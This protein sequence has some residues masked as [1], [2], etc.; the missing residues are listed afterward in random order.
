MKQFF[1]LAV[2][3]MALAFVSCNTQYAKVLK[4][5][6]N[7]YKLK[8]ADEYYSAKKYAHAQE[9]YQELLTTYLK[10]TPRYEDAYYRFAYAAYYLKDYEAAGLA[11]QTFME[12]FPNSDKVAECY[13]MEGYCLYKNS[14]KVELDQSSTL[15]AIATLQSF[16]TTYPSDTHSPDA[17]KLIDEC[18]QKLEDKEYLAAQLYLDLGYYK[19]AHIY[20]DMLTSDYPNSNRSDEYMFKTLLASYNYARKSYEY[21]QLDRYQT[22]LQECDDFL[23]QYPSSKFTPQA[24]SIKYNSQNRIT[25]LKK[26]IDKINKANEQTKKAG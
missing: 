4:S 12:N 19:S 18:N 24:V 25:Q 8:M 10:G 14:A 26:I 17:K 16:L 21:L 15:K 13:Y 22:T 3:F 2:L 6:D 7:E 23:A 1:S 9:L 11:F 5:K 20:F